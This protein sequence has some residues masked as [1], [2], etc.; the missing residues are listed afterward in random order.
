MACQLQ[1]Q[2]HKCTSGIDDA[3]RTGGSTCC[4][5]LSRLQR[6]VTFLKNCLSG[7]HDS[8]SWM[9]AKA[10]GGQAPATRVWKGLLR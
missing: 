3:S 8:W 7:W 2:G 5:E 10:G 6:L 1:E 9:P 4:G